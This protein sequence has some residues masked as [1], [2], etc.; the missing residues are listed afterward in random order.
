[1][2]MYSEDT[3]CFCAVG[4]M[5]CHEDPSR[6][7]DWKLGFT[8]AVQVLKLT[9]AEIYEITDFNDDNLSGNF[10]RAERYTRVLKWARER[11]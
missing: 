10:T 9:R 3:G 2:R 5:I 1:M 4:A 8:D 6:R 7:G 11:A